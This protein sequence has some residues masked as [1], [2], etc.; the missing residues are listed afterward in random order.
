MNNS[1]SLRM[2]QVFSVDSEPALSADNVKLSTI[3]EN[4][5]ETV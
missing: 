1:K 5:K 2:L 3:A 4:L